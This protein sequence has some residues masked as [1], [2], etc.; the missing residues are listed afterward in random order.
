MT[1]ALPQT[2]A[3]LCLV[4]LAS[5]VRA[6]GQAAPISAAAAGDDAAK[7]RRWPWFLRKLRVQRTT[8]PHAPPVVSG[9]VLTGILSGGLVLW[10]L[11]LLIR[12]HKRASDGRMQ[13]R[14]TSVLL[15]ALFGFPAGMCIYDR[16]C[17][18]S[19]KTPVSDAS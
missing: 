13:A 9:V 11:L 4:C 5:A 19:E 8:T 1:A 16:L 6:E 3:L 7:P 2:L 17:P 15:A 10:L 18:N 14:E 12:F